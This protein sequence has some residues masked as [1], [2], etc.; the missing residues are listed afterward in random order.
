MHSVLRV[1]ARQLK[2]LSQ[3]ILFEGG[4]RRLKSATNSRCRQRSDRSYVAEGGERATLAR[5][6][7]RTILYYVR[8][9][10]GVLQHLQSV[11]TDAERDTRYAPIEAH[12]PELRATQLRQDIA[13]RTQ[14]R[15]SL[16][17]NQFLT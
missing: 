16:Q 15:L 13:L 3:G 2:G 9:R 4:T 17:R 11:Q 7:R 8:H 10:G 1:E 14:D 5:P 6:R 12:N